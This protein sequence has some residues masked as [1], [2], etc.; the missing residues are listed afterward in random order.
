M[1][2]RTLDALNLVGQV[3]EHAESMVRRG[4]RY[5]GL[6]QRSAENM[7]TVVGVG[8]MVASA[9]AGSI[10]KTTAKAATLSTTKETAKLTARSATKTTTKASSKA[11]GAG[12]ETKTRKADTETNRNWELG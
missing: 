1:G 6:S 4:G 12:I 2:D 3:F 11:A 10:V 7:A 8:T 5:A 9:G